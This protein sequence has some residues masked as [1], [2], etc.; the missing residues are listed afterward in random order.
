MST[1]RKPTILI[2]EKAGSRSC[3][4]DRSLNEFRLIRNH[5]PREV[6]SLVSLNRPDLIILDAQM[7]D[8]SGYE[9]LKTLKSFY[10]TEKIPV[11]LVAEIHEDV[12]PCLALE[13]GAIDFMI[14]PISEHLI[15]AKIN[16]YIKIYHSLLALEERA[17]SAKEMNPNTGLPGNKAISR[18]VT[19]AIRTSQQQALIYADLDNFKSYNDKYGFGKGDEIIKLTGDVIADALSKLKKES[20][21]GHVGGDDFVFV[22]SVDE[23]K[24]VTDYVI[25]SFDKRIRECYT[26]EDRRRGFIISKD[27]RDQIQKYPIMTL[28]LAGVDLTEHSKDTRYEHVADICAEVKKYA[29]TFNQSCYYQDRRNK[30]RSKTLEMLYSSA[31]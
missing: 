1:L 28:S 15:T 21:L 2:T 25:R 23:V 20:F 5:D 14:K 19:N 12:E 27:R 29:K 6:F 31:I 24:R 11:V 9:L 10:K 22:V 18:Y 4:S 16:N 8:I 7:D 26:D 30:E 13:L 3:V 17:T